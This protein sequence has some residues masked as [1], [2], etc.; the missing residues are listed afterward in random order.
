M[1]S[2][3]QSWL[4]SQKPSLP[5]L[6]RAHEVIVTALNCGIGVKQSNYT[7]KKGSDRREEAQ[8]SCQKKWLVPGP[9]THCVAVGSYEWYS[10]HPAS[11]L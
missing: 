11:Y 10:L 3:P 1:E 2:C 9:A 5:L 7:R 6:D 4:D 8:S